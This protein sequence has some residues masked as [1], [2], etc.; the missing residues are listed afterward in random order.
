MT[1][2]AA[3]SIITERS[4]GRMAKVANQ[5]AVSTSRPLV[6]EL[7][8]AAFANLMPA[9]VTTPIPDPGPPVKIR[10]HRRPQRFSTSEPTWEGLILSALNQV[11][12]YP[13]QASFR[14]Q[15][16]VSYI[17]FVMHRDTIAACEQAATKAKQPVRCTI[18]IGNSRS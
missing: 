11:K 10:P 17:R 4:P 16:G 6:V 2:Q 13:R 18:R 3:P 15:Q 5:P 14:R 7:R 8:P 9:Q 12:R 1:I